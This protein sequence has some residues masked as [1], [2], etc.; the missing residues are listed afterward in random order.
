MTNNTKRDY[1]IKRT[2]LFGGDVQL[3]QNANRSND[4]GGCYRTGELRCCCSSDSSPPTI[5]SQGELAGLYFYSID[6]PFVLIQ[7]STYSLPFVKP[8]IQLEKYLSVENYFQ[9][10]KQKGKFQRKY[11]IESDKFLPKGLVTIREDGRVIGQ[12]HLCDLSQGDKQDLDC[13]DDSDVYFI[14]DVKILSQKRSS[15][16]YQ[17]QLTIIN[18]KNKSIKFQYKEIISAAK[19]TIDPNSDDQLLNKQIQILDNGLRITQDHFKSNEKIIF[20]YQILLEYQ[21]KDD[22]CPKTEYN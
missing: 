16:S 5:E 20:L 11:R 15:A 8:N 21:Q 13:G 14:R 17:I 6:Q 12:A 2:E 7:Q 10:Q 19:F 1:K 3:Q 22:Q 9:E 4:Y 18:S